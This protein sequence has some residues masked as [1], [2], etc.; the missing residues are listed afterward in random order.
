[1]LDTQTFKK[2]VAVTPLVSIDLIVM[3]GGHEVLLG[4]RNNRPA[5]GFWFVPGGRILKNEPIQTA[6]SRIITSELDLAT[7]ILCGGLKPTFYGTYEHFYQDCFAGDI[8]ISTHYVVMAYR[9]DVPSNFALPTA[10]GQHVEFKWWPIQ[11]ALSSGTVHQY[12]KNYFI[13]LEYR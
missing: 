10:D 8:G 3:R 12:T 5:Q 2:I 4:L 9:I 7:H 11:D 1:M 6:L 13:N